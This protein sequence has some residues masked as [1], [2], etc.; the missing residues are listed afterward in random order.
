MQTANAT[1]KQTR[2]VA[3][4]A[5]Q[6]L[7][8][9]FHDVHYWPRGLY[10][11]SEA[12]KQLMRRV[13]QAPPGGRCLDLGCGTGRYRPFIE[14]AGLE[15]NG[16][17]VVAP[18]A[19]HQSRFRLI[20]GD[21]IPYES[22]AFD[23]VC[24]F[25]VIEHFT[26]P[27]PM[28]AEVT[29]V[30]APGGYVFGAVAFHEHEHDSFFHLTDRGLRVILA[31][32][33]LEVESLW[34]SEYS[35]MVYTC[36]RFFGGG[37]RV[38]RGRGWGIFLASLVLTNAALPFFVSACGFQWLREVTGRRRPLADAAT[39]YFAARRPIS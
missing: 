16:A 2:A 23:V 31:R 39:I 30:T 14:A 7:R 27:E 8:R 9:L 36:Q 13:A 17:D 1:S 19:V 6:E 34:P 38:A 18:D 4:E 35:G 25:N 21:Q 20:E 32:H 11:R 33:D 28:F 29:R 15:W 5:E 22:G 10:W 37:G 24:L 26:N 3:A 12:H